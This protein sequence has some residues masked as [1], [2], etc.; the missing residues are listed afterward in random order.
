MANMLESLIHHVALPP[1]LP[2]KRESSIDR[3]EQALTDRLL[4]ATRTLCS[5]TEGVQHRQWDFTRRTL[6]T[7]KELCV[8]GKVSKT[9]VLYEFGRLEHNELLILHITQQNA[10]L[11]VRRQRELVV[12]IIA[13]FSALADQKYL[14]V[15]PTPIQSFSKPSRHP[16]YQRKSWRRKVH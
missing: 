13:K 3:I 2:G 9:S 14:G 6:Q 11:L 7:C 16:P 1:Q 15:G 12:P 10:G 5:V 4:K 8:G